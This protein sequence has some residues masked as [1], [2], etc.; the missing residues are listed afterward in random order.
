MII[1]INIKIQKEKD[2]IEILKY[3][4]KNSFLF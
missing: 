3:I 2:L 4:N 1:K